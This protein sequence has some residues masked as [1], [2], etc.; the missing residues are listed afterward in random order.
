MLTLYSVVSVFVLHLL[1]QRH[2]VTCQNYSPNFIICNNPDYVKNDCA[3]ALDAFLPCA[4]SHKPSAVPLKAGLSW[5][6]GFV[7]LVRA[8]I[9]AQRVLGGKPTP[10]HIIVVPRKTDIGAVGICPARLYTER[11]FTSLPG[12]ERKTHVSIVRSEAQVNRYRGGGI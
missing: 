11:G 1:S 7:P 12:A 10:G 2:D 9:R 3:C 4:L 8:R 6:W 5:R